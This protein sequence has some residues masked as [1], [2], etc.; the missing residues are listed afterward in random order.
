MMRECGV[1]KKKH[2][3]STIEIVQNLLLITGLATDFT[4]TS[5]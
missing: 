2:I 1:E 4:Y 5:R 3:V